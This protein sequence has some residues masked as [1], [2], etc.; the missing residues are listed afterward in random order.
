M[1]LVQG[2]SVPAAS[3]LPAAVTLVTCQSSDSAAVCNDRPCSLAGSS[4]HSRLSPLQMTGILVTL[5]HPVCLFA[6]ILP[7][8]VLNIFYILLLQPDC[9]KE[10]AG[11]GNRPSIFSGTDQQHKL[12][13]GAVALSPPSAR[14]L[15]VPWGGLLAAWLA[16]CFSC[17]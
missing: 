9:C 3:L 7:P 11:C 17:V 1:S 5:Q 4:K 12:I 16:S 10:H 6:L 2:S 13:L 14:F 15:P 8:R